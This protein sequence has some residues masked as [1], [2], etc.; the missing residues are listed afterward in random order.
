MRSR[1]SAQ[2]SAA[3]GRYSVEPNASSATKSCG[4]RRVER[5][6]DLL[7]PDALVHLPALGREREPE[8]ARDRRLAHLGRAGQHGEAVALE[9]LERARGRRASGTKTRASSRAAASSHDE[10]A[11]ARR[12]AA[13]SR[14]RTPSTVGTRRR[15]AGAASISAPRRSR[16]EPDDGRRG[17]RP[18]RCRPWPNVRFSSR[19]AFVSTTSVAERRDALRGSHGVRE[20]SAR[21]RRGRCPIGRAPTR[22]RS[23]PAPLRASPTSDAG[24]VST[25]GDA[26][27]G[28]RARPRAARPARARRA[29]RRR[30]ARTAA[31]PARRGGRS[32]ARSTQSVSEA[33]PSQEGLRDHVDHDQHAG[34]PRRRGRRGRCGSSRRAPRACSRRRSR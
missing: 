26:A 7:G 21:S 11:R 22:S 23:A 31:S 6:P 30:A 28:R 4:A 1:S 25:D 2:R 16:S 10:R 27:R 18:A 29:A 24:S 15:T 8:H 5:V 32:I 3:S 19:V 33:R 9:R 20:L 13:G 34:W 17:S 14:S 12:R